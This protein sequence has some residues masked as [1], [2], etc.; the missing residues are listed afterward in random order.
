MMDIG[1]YIKIIKNNRLLVGNVV[2]AFGIKGLGMIISVLAMPLYLNYFNDNMVLGVWFTLLTVVNWILSFD[3]GI[4]NGLRN[5]LTTALARKDYVEGRNLVSSSFVVLGIMT[6]LFSVVLYYLAIGID[7]NWMFNISDEILPLDLLRA[8]I[9]MTLFGIIVS[10]FLHIA[11]GMLFA[12]Q[13]ASATNFLHLLTNILMVGFLFCFNQTDNVQTKLWNISLAYALIVNV[14]YL[15]AFIYIFCFSEL[16]HCRPSFKTVSYR[17]SKMVLGLGMSFFVIQ[18]T[19]M[20]ITVTNEWFI[21]K[22]FAPEYCVEYQIYF[23]IFSLIGNFLML[24]MSPLWSAI[25]KA[26]A[27][28]RYAWIMKLQKMLYVVAAGCAVIQLLLLPLMQPLVNLWLN[29]KAIII[30]YTI[31][32]VF[33]FYSLVHIWLAILSTLVSGLGKLKMQLGFY[34]FAAVFKVGM[35]V[36]VS[37]YTDKWYVV[38]A[39][40][41]LGLLPYCIVQP[42]YIRKL[43]RQLSQSIKPQVA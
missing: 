31:A 4:G 10:F 11:R 41:A 27:E 36:L 3:V 38:V 33:L 37:Q 17:A 14:P 42:I 19:Y 8:C 5:H 20:I 39:I 24:A 40:T 35:I 12:L 16:K 22:F 13:L 32:S 28:E 15:L 26:Y 34:L 6:F 23:R 1:E 29:D 25:T 30:N 2:A 21:T 9:L 43:L 7:W 18:V